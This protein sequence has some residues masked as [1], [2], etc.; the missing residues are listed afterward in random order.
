MV[1]VQLCWYFL[2]LTSKL[3]WLKHKKY[4]KMLN[5]N[6]SKTHASQ[7]QG[8]GGRGKPGIS[9]VC[10]AHMSAYPPQAFLT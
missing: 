9:A 3:R 6:K 2:H 1:K 10:T 4:R 7:T 5:E 8:E